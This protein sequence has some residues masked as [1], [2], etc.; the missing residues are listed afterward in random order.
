MSIERERLVALLN[1]LDAS[2]TTLQRDMVRNEGRTGDWGIRGRT[3]DRAGNDASV[4]YPDG[5]G[6]LLYVTFGEKTGDDGID[7]EPSSLPWKNAKAKLVVLSGD[8]GRG[9]GGVSKAR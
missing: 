5:A 1:A 9:L 6:F 2:E 8:T 7:R 3:R 4:I